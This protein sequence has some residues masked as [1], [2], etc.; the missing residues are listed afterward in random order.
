MGGCGGRRAG[1]R[2][3]VADLEAIRRGLCG[4]REQAKCLAE[5]GEELIEW[6]CSQCEKK[7]ADD[8]DPYTVQLFS[9]RRLRLSGYPFKANDLSLETWE[10]LGVLEETLNGKR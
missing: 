2:P 4:E 9:I 1:Q 6:T 3:F 5:F 8:F 10:D 7:K